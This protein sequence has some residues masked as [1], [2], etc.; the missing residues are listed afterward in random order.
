MNAKS[1][2]KIN[3]YAKFISIINRVPVNRVLTAVKKYYKSLDAA[4]K[5]K[6]L[7]E[8]DTY[9]Q[10]AREAQAEQYKIDLKRGN[11]ND[12]T[13]QGMAPSEANNERR[14]N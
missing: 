2:R 10:K 7:V 9:L 12:N 1:A 5:G 13:S 4:G 6:M 14:S 11:L 3:E 8:I